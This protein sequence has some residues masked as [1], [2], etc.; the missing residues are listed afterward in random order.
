MGM[1]AS[2]ANLGFL[3]S[4]KN[5][6]GRQLTTLSNDKMMLSKDMQKVSKEY[7]EALNTK[8]L[9]WSNNSGITYSD[10]SYN[11]LMSP[12]TMNGNKPYLITDMGGRVVV[13]SK[14]QKYAEMISANGAPGGDWESNRAEILSSLTGI[15]ADDIEKADSAKSTVLISSFQIE[16]LKKDVADAK[17]AAYN[18]N[19]VEEFC[20]YFGNTPDNYVYGTDNKGNSIQQDYNLATHG[21]RHWALGSTPSS[22]ESALK[23]L[24]Q[25]LCNNIKNY[26]TDDDYKKFE[27]ACDTTCSSYTF[28]ET[29]GTEESTAAMYKDGVYAIRVDNFINQLM[30]AYESAGGE[31]RT[32]EKNNSIQYFMTVDKNSK[33]YKNYL[34]KQAELDAA[35]ANYDG[36]VDSS[37]QIFTAEQE[38]QLE[39]YDAIF[40][41][42]AEKGWT[43]NANVEDSDYL[44]QMLQ[45]NLYTITSISREEECDCEKGIHKIINSYDTDIATNCSNIFQ[46]NDSDIRE[47][48]LSEY[49][50]KKNLIN[51][52]ETRIDTRMQDLQTEQ[53]A[54]N[55]MIQGIETVRNDN[56]ERTF[57]IFG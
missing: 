1:S 34:A 5:T 35:I 10:L 29:I 56:V 8:V 4:R 44:N 12:S 57:S 16:E 25:V 26:L 7:Q 23:A 49:E 41:S 40:S 48:A 20:K 3:L 21:S 43:A 51:S 24:G 18:K 47:Q 27:D 36:A 45:N 14:Y 50:Y 17:D 19:T 28:A 53:S 30:S 46:V 2:Q 42:I 37:N 15:S 54:I 6:I 55:Q 39:F 13:D 31:S 22:A 11:N 32:N 52:K 33:E 38:A 9:K